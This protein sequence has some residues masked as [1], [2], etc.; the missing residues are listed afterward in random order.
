MNNPKHDGD[1]RR[2]NGKLVDFSKQQVVEKSPTVEQGQEPLVDN[3]TPEQQVEPAEE[4]ASAP[5]DTRKTFLRK[6][7]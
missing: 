6:K 5:S 7:R 3:D 4:T 2:I 1:W